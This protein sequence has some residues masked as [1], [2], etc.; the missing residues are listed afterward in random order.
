MRNR[1]GDRD[2]LISI[3]CHIV[4]GRAPREVNFEKGARPTYLE[5]SL[6]LRHFDGHKLIVSSDLRRLFACLSRISTHLSPN[7][8]DLNFCEDEK[9]RGWLAPARGSGGWRSFRGPDVP[10]ETGDVMPLRHGLV[11]KIGAIADR[12]LDR[13]HRAAEAAERLAVSLVATDDVRV[14]ADAADRYIVVED[15]AEHRLLLSRIW[16]KSV[17]HDRCEDTHEHEHNGQGHFHREKLNG[18]FGSAG[19]GKAQT[20]AFAAV[21]RRAQH[22]GV[23]VAVHVVRS[24]CDIENATIAAEAQL[25]EE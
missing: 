10:H 18:S 6:P 14:H 7:S 9:R 4:S 20:P 15:A 13:A 21:T 12:E 24:P 25:A 1:I 11:A 22:L 19:E 3:W 8:A 23:P 16:I 17:F 2:K 5:W